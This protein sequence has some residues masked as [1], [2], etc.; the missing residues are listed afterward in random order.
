LYVS[1]SET[2]SYIKRKELQAK[3]ISQIER[4]IAE[5]N[6][7]SQIPVKSAKSISQ[8]AKKQKAWLFDPKTKKWYT[9]EEF[10]DVFDRITRD[11]EK[12]IER[13]Q[14][15]DPVLAI[16][17]AF[18]VL[19]GDIQF[20]DDRKKIEAKRKKMEAFCMRVVGYYK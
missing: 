9:P 2:E 1:R 20:E 8:E 4:E 18:D 11:P 6:Q 5:R 14:I 16:A 7:I 17:E 10:F 15:K 19:K 13:M 3:R 12:T